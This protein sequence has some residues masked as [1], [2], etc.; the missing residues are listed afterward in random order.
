M[1]LGSSLGGALLGL[2]IL[3]IANW[4]KLGQFKWTEWRVRIFRHGLP[5]TA[6]LFLAMMA[7]AAA[8]YIGPPPDRIA[9]LF[10]ELETASRERVEVIQADLMQLRQQPRFANNEMVNFLEMVIEFLQSSAK[11]RTKEEYIKEGN[12]YVLYVGRAQ[13]PMRI[14]ALLMAGSSFEQAGQKQDAVSYYE[15]I[16]KMPGVS[17]FHLK[18]AGMALGNHYYEDLHDV[19]KAI[20]CWQ[21]VLAVQPTSGILQNIA[22]AYADIQDWKMAEDFFVKA[23]AHL[24]ETERRLDAA[25]RPGR[26]AILYSNWANYIG[27]RIRGDQPSP[28]MESAEYKRGVELA[29]K[30]QSKE[31]C[32]MD[33][34]WEECR[35]SIVVGDWL[36]ARNALRKARA[37]L[38]NTKG[39]D[40]EFNYDEIGPE[41]NLWLECVIA[42]SDPAVKKCSS[43]MFARMRESFD[44]FEADPYSTILAFLKLAKAKGSSI[45]DDEKLVAEMVEKHFFA[46]PTAFPSPLSN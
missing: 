9:Q 8:I 17:R 22:L 15:Q 30:A 40:E 2:S 12:H 21:Q 31:E 11:K 45:N 3:R 41:M 6:F 37:H 5:A 28:G 33:A 1:G 7:I 13:P 25:K 34:Y 39:R 14:W 24:I 23:E 18:W 29:Q 10:A 42:Y 19:P 38:K 36:S 20:A 4:T 26:W 16:M 43:E 44:G 32:Y 35:L 46:T 27:R